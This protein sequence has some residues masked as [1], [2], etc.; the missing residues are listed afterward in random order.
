[1]NSDRLP[2]YFD[3]ADPD[4]GISSVALTTKAPVLVAEAP[5]REPTVRTKW[6][7]TVKGPVVLD[8]WISR[9]SD[10]YPDVNARLS[11]T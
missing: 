11:C 4:P 10:P 9:T 1:M 3:I 2:E 7:E 5:E 8:G 6:F